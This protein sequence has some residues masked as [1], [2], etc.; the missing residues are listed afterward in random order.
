M[1]QIRTEMHIS[2]LVLEEHI[3]KYQNTKEKSSFLCGLDKTHNELDK[4][5]SE[6]DMAHKEI[7]HFPVG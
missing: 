2:L 1:C 4:T 7:S 6:I 3:G 5:H